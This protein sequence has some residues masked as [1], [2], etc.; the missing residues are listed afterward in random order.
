ML[1]EHGA[2]SGE[3]TAARLESVAGLLAA[4][5]KEPEGL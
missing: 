2:S 4:F 5:I 3:R 1:A